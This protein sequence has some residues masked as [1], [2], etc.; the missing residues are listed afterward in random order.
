M[1]RPER[2]VCLTPRPPSS[3]S[4][5]AGGDRVVGCDRL[6]GPSAGARAE[7][8]RGRVQTAHAIGILALKPD[9]VLGFSDLQAE[10]V[11]ELIAR[12]A[13]VLITNQRTIAE[14]LLAIT[15]RRGAL[16][17]S[18]A[19]ARLAEGLRAELDAT[20]AAVPAG[21]R[22]PRVFF[23]EWDSPLISGIS[24]VSEIIELCGGE[25]LFP[26]LRAG[27]SATQRIV[28]PAEVVRRA[29][30]SSSQ[31]GAGKKV[32]PERIRARAGGSG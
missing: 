16:G 23:E 12:G 4:R 25:D 30:S 19:G 1:P 24:W 13:Q 15:N 18:E 21:E 2:V 9:L 26:E 14:T 29:P 5:W 3:R 20:A 6:R 7:A 11:R 10:I 17:E 28:D 8:P 27:G 22:R 32:R 31:A